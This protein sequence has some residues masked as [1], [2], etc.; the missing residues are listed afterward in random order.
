MLTSTSISPRT[1]ARLDTSYELSWRPSRPIEVYGWFTW[2]L[3]INCYATYL[4]DKMKEHILAGSVI[5]FEGTA[6]W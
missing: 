1:Y 6:T 5:Q 4:V 2:Q 3:R